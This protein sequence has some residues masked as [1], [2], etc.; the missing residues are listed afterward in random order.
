MVNDQLTSRLALKPLT[1]E[2]DNDT[3]YLK[4]QLAPQT[5]LA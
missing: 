5:C 3:F 1:L 4:Y 2:G